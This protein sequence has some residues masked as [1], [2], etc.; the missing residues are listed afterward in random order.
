MKQFKA[1]Q[2]A[3]AAATRGVGL[4]VKS[5][6]AVKFD[7]SGRVAWAIETSDSITFDTLKTL[8]EIYGT[9]HINVDSEAREGGYCET[10]RYSYN[11]TIITVVGPTE[12]LAEECRP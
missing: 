5:V 12:V 9:T 2:K 8:S 4:Y 1:E 7:S 10:C 6:R 3:L 11:A